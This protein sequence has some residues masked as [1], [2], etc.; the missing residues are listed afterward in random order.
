MLWAELELG[1]L[2][3]PTEPRS[4]PAQCWDAAPRAP[5][6]I[7]WCHPSLLPTHGSL[8]LSSSQPIR[9]AFGPRRQ[10]RCF[11]SMAMAL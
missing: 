9:G 5:P 2:C 8:L 6:P 10:W 1:A 3:C 7:Q 4:A 11:I